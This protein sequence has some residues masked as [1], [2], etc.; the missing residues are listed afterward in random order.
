MTIVIW[1]I[2]TSVKLIYCTT[3]KINTCLPCMLNIYLFNLKIAVCKVNRLM[4]CIIIFVTLGNFLFCWNVTLQF[5]HKLLSR[6][7]STSFTKI[8]NCELIH[9]IMMTPTDTI[10]LQKHQNCAEICDFGKI[11]KLKPIRQNRIGSLNK[12]V[13]RYSMIFLDC[14]LAWDLTLQ[15]C[16]L[17]W[18]GELL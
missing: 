15:P 3:K 14:V 16:C 17:Y 5:L 8:Q 10:E 9:V 11:W 6:N 4:S 18:L 2:I 1:T 13:T 7:T 12:L